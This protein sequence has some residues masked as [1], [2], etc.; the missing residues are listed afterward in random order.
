MSITP[1]FHTPVQ[2]TPMQDRVAAEPKAPA[3]AQGEAHADP[4]DMIDVATRLSADIQAF[5]AEVEANGVPITTL[6]EG[7]A[8]EAAENARTVLGGQSLSIA[9]ANPGALAGFLNDG[10]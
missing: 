2:Q 4:K 10:E 7:D 3:D 5:L 9:N 1:V 8:R 6:S